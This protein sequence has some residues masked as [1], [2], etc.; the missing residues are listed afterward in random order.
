MTDTTATIVV[1]ATI[2][3][4]CPLASLAAAYILTHIMRNTR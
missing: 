3:I 1:F 2:L 4:G